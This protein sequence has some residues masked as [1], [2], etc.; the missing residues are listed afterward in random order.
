MQE[1]PVATWPEVA[2]PDTQARLIRSAR[3]DDY[4]LLIALPAGPP[5]PE[6]FPVIY[7][8]DANA[9]FATVTEACRRGARRSDATGVVPALVVGIGSP[10]AA[11]YDTTRRRRDY[12][13]GPAAG[14]APRREVGGAAAFLAF[15][16]D[17]VKPLIAREFAVDAAR[18]T[19]L[20]H[21]LAGLF[22][23][24]VLTHRPAS[25]QS[26]VAISP[27]IWWDEA[28]L[29]TGFAGVARH[30]AGGGRLRGL[31]CVGE[32]EEAL[33]PWQQ[34]LGTRAA[35][36]AR[37]AERGMVRRNRAFA[38]DLAAAL[39]DGG[40]IAFQELPG[41]DHSSAVPAAISLALRFALAPRGFDLPG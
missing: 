15:L 19:L 32:W 24:W 16:E 39:P 29:R 22:T 5:P 36:E 31:I 23:L 6:G 14:E 2:L 41:Q 9:D 30:V 28:L 11:L 34:G 8:L 17:E 40:R 13:P 37:R 25:F 18:Q 35:V 27:S 26:Y 38:A 3:G 10:S 7:L 33:A 12:T 4:R 20:G 21:S 1:K